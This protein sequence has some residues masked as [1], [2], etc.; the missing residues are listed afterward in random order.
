ME[1]PVRSADLLKLKKEIKGK[2]IGIVFHPFEENNKVVENMN[3]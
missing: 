1:I 2:V 3:E